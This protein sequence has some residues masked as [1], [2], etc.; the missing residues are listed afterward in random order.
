MN[1]HPII[2]HFPI[3]LLTVY[4]I[5]EIITAFAYQDHAN[6]L[7]LKKRSLWIGVLT[8]FPAFGSGEQAEH[9]VGKSYMVHIHEQRA[10]IARN[11]FV[12]LGLVYLCAEQTY[13]TPLTRKFLGDNG[14]RQCTQIY[15]FCHRYKITVI[16]AIL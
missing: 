3:V 15:T 16:L 5:L 8:I 4:C 9:I 2:V 7:W 1:L 12:V 13:I 6:L 14:V 11:I 10:D